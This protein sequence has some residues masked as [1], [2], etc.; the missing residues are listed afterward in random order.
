MS[1]AGLP[2]FLFGRGSL[3]DQLV[4]DVR[5]YV[6]A[7]DE[8]NRDLL[9]PMLAWS[10]GPPAIGDT[11]DNSQGHML[12]TTWLTRMPSRTTRGG[13]RFSTMLTRFCTFTTAMSG[14]VP[15]SK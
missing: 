8:H 4:C 9:A 7:V 6:R 5:T 3:H 1:F 13:S 12:G 10:P 11:G 2:P 15:G 14:S